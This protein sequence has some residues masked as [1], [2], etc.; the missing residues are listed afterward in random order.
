MDVDSPEGDLV[1]TRAEQWPR[2]CEQVNVQETRN[3]TRVT[4]ELDDELDRWLIVTVLAETLTTR[5]RQLHGPSVVVVVG[6]R[7][8]VVVAGTVVVVVWSVVHVIGGSWMVPAAGELVQAV[9]VAVQLYGTS[10]TNV[11]EPETVAAPNE[12]CASLGLPPTPTARVPPDGHMPPTTFAPVKTNVHELGPGSFADVK[13]ICTWLPLRGTNVPAAS[14][15]CIMVR[16]TLSMASASAQNLRNR[17]ERRTRIRGNKIAPSRSHRDRA[18]VPHRRWGGAGT[19][20]VVRR[21]LSGHCVV[22]GG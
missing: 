22:R 19:G 20:P 10:S 13:V 9:I 1:I 3:C 11:T 2:P 16:G 12:H 17:M 8:V 7:V 14:A 18:I 5:L 4:E 15:G 6:G 21:L